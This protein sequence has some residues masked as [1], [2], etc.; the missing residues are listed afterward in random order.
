M[1]ERGIQVR[2]GV[3]EY[4]VPWA[5]VVG[6]SAFGSKIEIATEEAKVISVA[7]IQSANLT[8]MLG[9]QGRAGRYLV[10]LEE[11]WHSLDAAAADGPVERSVG[12]T[13]RWALA[14]ALGVCV[15]VAV[16]AIVP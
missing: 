2:N 3:F 11:T 14:L 6:L 8:L 10:R 12:L 5:R 9:R 16:F 15:V 13:P 1:Y 4:W 7:A